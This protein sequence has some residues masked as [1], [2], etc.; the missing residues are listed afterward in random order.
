MNQI[1]PI[2]ESKTTEAI[3][4]IL[5]LHQKP[6]ILDMLLKMMYFIDRQYLARANKSLTNDYYLIKKTGLVPK[7]TPKLISQLQKINYLNVSSGRGY[8]FL[9]RSPNKGKLTLLEREIVTCVYYQKK[10][11]NPFNILDWNYDLMYLKNHLKNQG[12]NLI[13][14]VEI[15]LNLDKSE[16]EIR[17]YV[18]SRLAV[19]NILDRELVDTMLQESLFNK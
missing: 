15:L 10:D 7:H 11:V 6:M 2:D 19:E 16:A 12:D 17:S 13:T 14:P 4:L 8:I 18:Y 1:L 5:R 9:V 3:A